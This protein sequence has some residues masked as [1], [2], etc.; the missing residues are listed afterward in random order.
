MPFTFSLLTIPLAV[1]VVIS[2][3][4]AASAKYLVAVVVPSDCF[5][6]FT[7]VAEGCSFITSVI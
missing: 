2:T 3:D 4:F 1:A 5:V 6:D 7:S